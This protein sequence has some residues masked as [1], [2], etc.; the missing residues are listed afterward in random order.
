MSEWISV[1]DRLPN[2]G[3]IVWCYSKNFLPDEEEDSREEIYDMG[4]VD[5]D[6]VEMYAYDIDATHWRYPEPPCES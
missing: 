6:R 2:V 4:G 3:A 1:E 5:G